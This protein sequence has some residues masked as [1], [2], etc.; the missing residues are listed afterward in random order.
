[1][2]EVFAGAMAMAIFGLAIVVIMIFMPTGLAGLVKFVGS[3][4]A[5]RLRPDSRQERLFFTMP[6]RT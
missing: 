3:K 1:M 6:R 4:M 2:V 5:V